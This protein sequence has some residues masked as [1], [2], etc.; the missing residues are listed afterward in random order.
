MPLYPI[1]ILVIS[2]SLKEKIETKRIG[3]IKVGINQ[4]NLLLTLGKL[5]KKRKAKK[6]ETPPKKKSKRKIISAKLISK[7][8]FSKELSKDQIAAAT[9]K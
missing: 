4:L 2:W 8:K 6:I 9:E 5:N 1:F 7:I 3:N